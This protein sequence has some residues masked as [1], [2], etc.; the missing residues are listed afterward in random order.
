[1]QDRFKTQFA[2]LAAAGKSALIPYTLLGYPD[3]ATS[4]AAARTMIEAGA[5]AL[6]LGMAFSDP[7]AD[8][9]VLQ[10]AAH[11]VVKSGFSTST[12]FD[13]L[14]DVRALSNDI[15]IAILVYFN[16]V[17]SFG[18]EAF[19]KRAQECGADAVLIVDLP[20]GQPQST[21]VTRAAQSAGVKQIFII[22]PATKSERLAVILENAGAFVYVVSRLGTTGCQERYSSDLQKTIETLQ[23]RT[24]LPACVGFGISTPEQARG[25]LDLGAKGVITGSRVIEL[26]DADVTALTTARQSAGK[27]AEL[28]QL[29]DYL[30]RMIRSVSH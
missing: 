11:H 19:F 25:M 16:T 18:I 17:L 23:A 15:P 1:M 27:P 6:E 8:G 20:P 12:A 29:K 13:T 21:L 26:I 2:S 4:N 28:R 3:R 30:E 22:S 14:A 5:S 7:V 9:P 10:N 24:N